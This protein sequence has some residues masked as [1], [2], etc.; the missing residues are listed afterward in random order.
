MNILIVD[1]EPLA[2]EALRNV[3]TDHP[4]I[5]SIREACDGMQALDLLKEDPAEIILLDIQMPQMDGFAFLR[6]IQKS[7]SRLPVIVFVTAF[8][9]FAIRAFEQHAADYVL[10]PF[11]KRR[12]L[13]AVE[14]AGERWQSERASSMI[15][16]LPAL[17][18]RLRQQEPSRRIAVKSK[19]RVIFLDPTSINFV[20]AEGNYFILHLA[21]GGAHM[22]RG[23]MSDI[24]EKL[25]PF[26]F[27]R[28]H[29]SVVVNMSAVKD[30]QPLPSGEYLLRTV[31]GRDF[32]VTRK[33]KT[34][35]SQLVTLSVG[36][37][38][39]AF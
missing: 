2:R 8:D 23:M 27:I 21:N 26:G 38:K 24:E 12:V 11:E 28:I 16:Q 30:V 4:R 31:S 3:L 39:S 7:A 33:Y 22:L 17:L 5:Q 18:Q 29:R 6:E 36:T 37:P 25:K 1:D 14:H 35:L 20:L 15:E 34:N 32:H 13:A 9:E 19:G 10:K